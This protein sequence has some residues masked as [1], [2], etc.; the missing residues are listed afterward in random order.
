MAQ[1]TGDTYYLADLAMTAGTLQAVLVVVPLVVAVVAKDNL[2]TAC[3]V[4]MATARAA[5]ARKIHCGSCALQLSLAALRLLLGSQGGQSK[6]HKEEASSK[7]VGCHFD[8]CDGVCGTGKC[9]LVVDVVVVGKG[10]G[11][12]GDNRIAPKRGDKLCHLV[13]ADVGVG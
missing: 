9:C 7:P 4:K 1:W 6:A 13:V 3:E 8:G 2:A 12:G 5:G 11:E 10:S